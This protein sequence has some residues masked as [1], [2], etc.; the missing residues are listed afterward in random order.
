MTTEN[1]N[2]AIQDSSTNSLE[3]V[4][5]SRRKWLRKAGVAAPGLL[6]LAS[7]PAMASSCT[8]SGFMSAQVGT[9]LTNYNPGA[10]NGWSPGN[11]KN[12]RGQITNLAWTQAGISPSDTFDGQFSTSKLTTISI[13]KNVGGS[14]EATAQDYTSEFAITMQDVLGGA[15]AVGGG[16]RGITKHAAASLL[17]ASFLKNVGSMTNP[18]PWMLNYQRPEEI[19]AFYLLYEMTILNSATMDSDYFLVVGGSPYIDSR[20]ASKSDYASFFD[21]IS[22]GNAASGWDWSA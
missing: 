3:G 5:S 12:D 13:H 7:K 9:S 19:I 8:I 1:K 14:P 2:Q 20:N 10:C 21:S 18:E 6:L 22:D 16:S 11:W 4:G 15:I 17:N